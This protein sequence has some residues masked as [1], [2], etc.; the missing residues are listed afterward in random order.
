MKSTYTIKLSST[1]LAV[2][3]VTMLEEN[4]AEITRVNVPL[5]FR[6]QGHG[7]DLLQQVIDDA[8]VEEINLQLFI[9]PYGSMTYE[10]LQRWYEDNG[11]EEAEDGRFVRVFH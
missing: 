7:S 8:D 1:R 5:E 6:G 2:L 4:L 9:N 10:Q 3:D 11:F